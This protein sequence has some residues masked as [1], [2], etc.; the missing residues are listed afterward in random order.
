MWNKRRD[1]EPPRPVVPNVPAPA[2]PTPVEAKKE[3]MPMSSMPGGR[4]E[5]EHRSSA[6]GVA[7]IGKAVKV[8]GQ[9]FS[10]EDLYVD[11]DLEGSV[12][13]LEHKLTIGPNGTVHAGIKAREVL[14]LGTIH[15]NVEAAEKIEI[16]KDAKLVGDIR[17]AR[18]IIEDGA[19]FKGSID[20]V[21][22]EPGKTPHKPPQPAPAAAAAPTP[23]AAPAVPAPEG[24]R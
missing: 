19:Y 9:I 8:V 14:A 17:T 4:F 5:P 3:T 21:K 6:G 23:V 11:G 10:K 2:A 24:K 15:G 12:E 7:T 13:A 18:I 16:R 20:I 1:E 22:P